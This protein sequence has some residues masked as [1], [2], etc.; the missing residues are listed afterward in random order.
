M[1]ALCLLLTVCAAVP[2]Y[3]RFLIAICRERWHARICYLVRLE[4]A[5]SKIPAVGERHE[6]VIAAGAA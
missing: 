2:F 4:H 1:I 3:V 5:E 6:S